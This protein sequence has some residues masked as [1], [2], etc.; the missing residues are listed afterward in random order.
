MQG[1]QA[2]H[3]LSAEQCMKNSGPLLSTNSGH[4]NQG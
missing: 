1:I 2:A 4:T 3:F